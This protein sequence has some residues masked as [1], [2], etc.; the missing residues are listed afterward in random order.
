MK[1]SITLSAFAVLTLLATTAS[2]GVYDYGQRDRDDRGFNRSRY[3]ESSYRGRDYDSHY[4]RTDDFL[5]RG[6]YP[7]YQSDYGRSYGFR[8][9]NTRCNSGYSQRRGLHNGYARIGY[10]SRRNVYPSNS[11]GR[12]RHNGGILGLLTGRGLSYYGR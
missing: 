8:S 4:A 5:R 12:S 7:D 1:H 3:H 9:G 11:Y 10:G 2:A 6:Q